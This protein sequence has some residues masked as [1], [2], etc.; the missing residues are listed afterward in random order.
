MRALLTSLT[1]L[2]AALVLSPAW[3]QTD[4]TAPPRIASS[5][6]QGEAKAQQEFRMLDI[7]GDG[8]LSR[9]EVMLFPRLT[10]AFDEA[11]TDRDHYVSYEEVRAFAARYRAERDRNR[12]PKPDKVD[13]AGGAHPQ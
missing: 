6:S 11:D 9:A 12:A 3:G 13:A 2:A 1:T 5:P 8:K 4:T 7:N 10:A